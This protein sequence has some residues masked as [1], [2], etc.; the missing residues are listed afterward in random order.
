M[1][2]PLTIYY[3]NSKEKCNFLGVPIYYT[4]C[5]REHL[6]IFISS[7]SNF[8]LNI[9]IS[10]EHTKKNIFYKKAPNP[11]IGYGYKKNKC[12]KTSLITDNKLPI[13][14]KINILDTIYDKSP[15][16]SEKAKNNL[17]K[18]TNKLQSCDGEDISINHHTLCSI[19]EYF[20]LLFS[21]N[22]DQF[23][24]KQKCI[25]SKEEFDILIDFLQNDTHEDLHKLIIILD[26]INLINE[27]IIYFFIDRIV[28]LSND[29]ST[30]DIFLN[31]LFLVTSTFYLDI[32]NNIAKNLLLVFL[33]I[34]KNQK[35]V[36]DYLSKN[37]H[38]LIDML[39]HDI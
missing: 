22:F 2:Y 36:K 39:E 6:F 4:G 30:Y 17:L 31:L 1:E 12:K 14:I 19:S 24:M 9:K 8:Q 11:T 26:K 37:T 23:K 32:K 21:D 5:N 13:S 33:K 7:E 34:N 38:L 29:E 28:K 10:S 20:R 16:L 35:D 3:K 15:I 27:N 18:D 25:L